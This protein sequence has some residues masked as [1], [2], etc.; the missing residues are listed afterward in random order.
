MQKLRTE[1]YKHQAGE[2]GGTLETANRLKE[3]EKQIEDDIDFGTIDD[4]PS[5]RKTKTGFRLADN[6]V[7]SP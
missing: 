5:E 4:I 1:N 2:T 6:S 3:L 7:V